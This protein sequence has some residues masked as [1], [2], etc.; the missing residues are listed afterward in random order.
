[1]NHPIIHQLISQIA[2][3]I[4]SYKHITHELAYTP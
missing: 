3:R 4:K 1:M 2:E